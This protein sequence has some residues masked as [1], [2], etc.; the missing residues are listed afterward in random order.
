M[1]AQ[2]ATAR[3]ELQLLVDARDETMRLAKIELISRDA[4]Y[5]IKHKGLL[6]G[7]TTWAATHR[8][9]EEDQRRARIFREAQQRWMKPGLAV[10]FIHWRTRWQAT[11]KRLRAADHMTDEEKHELLEATTRAAVEE[12]MTLRLQVCA[13]ALL[14]LCAPSC[15]YRARSCPPRAHVL[16]G[17]PP[18]CRARVHLIVRA[19]SDAELVCCA[20]LRVTLC[21]LHL[22]SSPSTYD[23]CPPIPPE[24]SFARA[25]RI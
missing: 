8:Q 15:S 7:W 18:G 20:L 11:I 13:R 12:A 3:D 21:Y 25:V 16:R 19:L 23:L 4:L 24:Y 5:R 14:E 10:P 9:H 1:C 2:V 22:L 6:R 17:L